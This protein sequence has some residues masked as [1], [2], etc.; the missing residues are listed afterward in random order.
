MAKLEMFSEH[1]R[2]VRQRKA[3]EEKLRRLGRAY[4]D[5]LVS[6]GEYGVQRTLLNDALNSLVEPEHGATMTA[7]EI[8]ENLG[9]VWDKATLDEKHRPADDDA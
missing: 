3:I 2:I 8:L 1:D 7:G 6:D 5:G 4:V 9:Y